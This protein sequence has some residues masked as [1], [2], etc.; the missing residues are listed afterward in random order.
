VNGEAYE[1]IFQRYQ[2][3]LWEQMLYGKR[4]CFF[5]VLQ[6]V[7]HKQRMDNFRDEFTKGMK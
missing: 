1:E 7:L 2:Q 6:E 3:R 4:G 5:P